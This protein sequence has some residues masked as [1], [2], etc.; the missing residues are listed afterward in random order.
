VLE[1]L[2]EKIPKQEREGGCRGVLFLGERSAHGE[3]TRRRRTYLWTGW[4]AEGG[5]MRY[6]IRKTKGYLKG[7][8]ENSFFGKEGCEEQT[9]GGRLRRPS[10]QDVEII[11]TTGGEKGKMGYLRLVDMG[12]R[13]KRTQRRN[14]RNGE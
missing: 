5:V 13:M 14:C 9:D 7:E 2:S 12:A 8:I 10:K 3:W 4:H 11:P 1:S 6:P